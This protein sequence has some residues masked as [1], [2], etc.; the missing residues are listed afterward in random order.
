MNLLK[1]PGTVFCLSYIIFIQSFLVK[2][3]LETECQGPGLSSYF[4]QLT[5]NQI[6]LAAVL[7]IFDVCMKNIEDTWPGI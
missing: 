5:H 2:I 3:M 4:S 1:G 6:S 7:R